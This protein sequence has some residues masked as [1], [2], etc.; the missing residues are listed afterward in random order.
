[1]A[2]VFAGLATAAKSAHDYYFAESVSVNEPGTA[3]RNERAVAGKART[4]TR[5][6]EYGEQ[7]VTVRDCRF[8]ALTTL[9]HDAVV[10][11]AGEQWAIEEVTN[12][13]ASGLEVV[14]RR[15][16]ASELMRPNYR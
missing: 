11:I 8:V 3:V 9:R 6:N 4:E 15:V 10:T 7:R 1:M 5:Q 16:E 14:L 2:N 12:R 13:S